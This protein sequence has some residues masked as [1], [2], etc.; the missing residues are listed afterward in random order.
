MNGGITTPFDLM[1]PID[2]FAEISS[3]PAGRL[4]TSSA[5][6]AAIGA[7]TEGADVLK[8]HDGSTTSRFRFR[9]CWGVRTSSALPV[10]RPGAARPADA[11]PAGRRAGT[12]GVMR[13]KVRLVELVSA[14]LTQV[15]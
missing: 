7:A 15:K 9:F 8:C 13:V 2:R 3:H 5:T 6:V 12:Y 4:A 11:A 14:D 1:L 10:F